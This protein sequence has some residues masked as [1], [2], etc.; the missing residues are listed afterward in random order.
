MSEK[1]EQ[2]K[3]A[4]TVNGEDQFHFRFL[5]ELTECNTLTHCVVCFRQFQDTHNIQY[6]IYKSIFYIAHNTRPN[7]RLWQMQMREKE[8]E[9]TK[10]KIN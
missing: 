3:Q 7:M 10:K 2:I 6:T 4:I 8:D 9:E 1:I 5:R